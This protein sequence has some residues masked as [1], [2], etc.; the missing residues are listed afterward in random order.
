M[1]GALGA[2]LI[3]AGVSGGIDLVNQGLSNMSNMKLAKYAYSKDLE[4]WNRNNEYNNPSAQM[5]RLSSAGLNPNLVYGSGTVTGNT[6]QTLPKFQAP[7]MSYNVNPVS[8]GVGMLNAYQDFE[9]KNAQIDNV[10]AQTDLTQTRNAIEAVNAAYAA[11]YGYTDKLTQNRSRNESAI[12]APKILRKKDE[13]AGYQNTIQSVQAKNAITLMAQ[14][15][16]KNQASIGYTNASSAKVL[17][18]ELYRAS[19][20]KWFTPNAISRIGGQVLGA[21]GNWLGRFL[22]KKLSSTINKNVTYSK[23]Y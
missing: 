12:W 5:S 22:P 9:M 3:T 15:I 4:M 2:G 20:N 13:L 17:Q 19:E 16:A 23:K 7:T 21:A 11:D 14:Q 8:K 10:K 18:D 1:I 6:S